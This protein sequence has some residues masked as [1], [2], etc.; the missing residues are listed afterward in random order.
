MTTPVE[1]FELAKELRVAGSEVRLRAAASRAYYALY[2]HCLAFHNA[3]MDAAKR[4]NEQ[5]SPVPRG[6]H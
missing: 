1:L 6:W 4:V 5:R 2:H 3:L